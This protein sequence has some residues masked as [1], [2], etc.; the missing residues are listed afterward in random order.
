VFTHVAL[1][2]LTSGDLGLVASDQPLGIDTAKVQQLLDQPEVRGL[3]A[4]LGR[5][6]LPHTVDQV[7]AGQL[8]GAATV[9]AFCQGFDAPLHEERPQMEYRAPRDFFAGASAKKTLLQLDR[10]AGSQTG[11]LG[12][13]AMADWLAEHPLDEPRRAALFE[14]LRAV[15]HPSDTPLATALTPTEGL[16]ERLREPLQAL[17]PLDQTPESR[18]AAVCQRL[19]RRADWL[20]Q[21]PL[22]ILGPVSRDPQ[23]QRWAELCRTLPPPAL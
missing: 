20:V 14:H 19:R 22:T 11:Q 5:A 21:R 4:K 17:P 12:D 6:D 8:C 7:L 9:A 18:R 13:V 16:P 1:Y 10:R 23:V 3:F 15:N 2:R